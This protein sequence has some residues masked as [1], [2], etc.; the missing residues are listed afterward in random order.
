MV[1]FILI[2]LILLGVLGGGARLAWGWIARPAARGV[3]P[4]WDC[5]HEFRRRLKQAGA[6]PLPRDVVNEIVLYEA[7]V[8]MSLAQMGLP[9]YAN[10]RVNLSR[11][12]DL[13]ARH[14]AWFHQGRRDIAGGEETFS[15]LR[16][17]GLV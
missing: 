8:A 15:I 1:E 6:P 9:A 4:G 13:Q 10:W 12:L 3:R 7:Q 2:L 14:I 5:H 11:Q 17:H 16:R